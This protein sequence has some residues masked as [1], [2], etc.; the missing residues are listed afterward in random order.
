MSTGNGFLTAEQ[1]MNLIVYDADGEKIGTIG[2]VYLDDTTGLPEW[3]TVRTGWFGTKASFVPLAG[4]RSDGQALHIPHTGNAVKDAPRV[5]ADEHMDIEEER[6]LYR[7]YGLGD[8]DG[9][10]DGKVH[11]TSVDA[12]GIATGTYVDDGEGRGTDR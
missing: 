9:D 6:R 3:V 4:A 5:D 11:R 7:H 10:G 12:P 8:S 1:L 2:R